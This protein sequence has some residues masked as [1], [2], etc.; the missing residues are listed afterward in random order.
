M[1]DRG[2]RPGRIAAPALEVAAKAFATTS[3]DSKVTLVSGTHL[4]PYAILSLI[5]A[6]GMGEVYKALDTR[7]N[8]AVAIKVLPAHFSENPEMK[9]RFE[10]ETKTVAA[11]PIPTSWRFSILAR[12]RESTMQLRNSW[13]ARRC[14]VSSIPDRFRGGRPSRLRW[15]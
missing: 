2:E 14:A 9:E 4:G 6:G 5:G 11:H 10:R 13:K 15:Q 3:G 1:D 7:L 8:R 12:S